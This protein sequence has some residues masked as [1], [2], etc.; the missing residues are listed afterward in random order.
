MNSVHSIR[1]ALGLTQI[2]LASALGVTQ[3]TICRY[4]RTADSKVIT[5]PPAFMAIRLVDFC[6]AKGLQIT[7]DHVYG[8]APLLVPAGAA[9]NSIPA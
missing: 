1:Q 3:P 9:D 6:A 4:E 8:L 5:T 7:L 2:G